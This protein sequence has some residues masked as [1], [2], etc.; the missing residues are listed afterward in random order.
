MMHKQI[1]RG[2]NSEWW[3][4]CMYKPLGFLLYYEFQ[5]VGACCDDG[6]YRSLLSCTANTGLKSH[7]SPS[8]VCVRRVWSQNNSTFIHISK[9]ALPNVLCIRIAQS[10]EY[11]TFLYSH[12]SDMISTITGIVHPQMFLWIFIYPPSC[13]SKPVWVS[14]YIMNSHELHYWQ[15]NSS[16]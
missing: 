15:S 2:L 12:L 10:V 1:S 11:Q 6:N 8:A 16:R 4:G 5:I 3:V 9:S 13:H 14:F 7:Y